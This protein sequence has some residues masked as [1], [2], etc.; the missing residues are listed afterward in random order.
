[1]FDKEVFSRIIRLNRQKQMK[2]QKQIAN[3]VG[4]SSQTVSGWEAGEKLPTVDKAVALAEE[5]GV[6][7][8]WL[9]GVQDSTRN[10]NRAFL[11]KADYAVALLALIEEAVLT[12]VDSSSTQFRIEDE[13]LKRFLQSRKA[14]LDLQHSGAIDKEMAE[15]FLSAL[16]AQLRERPVPQATGIESA[17]FF[18]ANVIDEDLSTHDTDSC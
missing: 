9:V 15:T 1:M 14:L 8:D 2:T 18:L 4:V 13:D 5:L 10:A 16:D 3:A 17:E 6:S 7:L 11:T 12:P